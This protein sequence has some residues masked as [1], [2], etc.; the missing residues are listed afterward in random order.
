MRRGGILQEKHI[1]FVHPLRQLAQFDE[2][3]MHHHTKLTL[4][5][6]VQ[7]ACTRWARQGWGIYTV[8]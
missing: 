4:G 6:Q 2:K 1:A 8:E 5:I 7:S 3:T